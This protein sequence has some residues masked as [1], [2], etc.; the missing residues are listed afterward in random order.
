MTVELR[1]A[2]LSERQI[3]V[4]ERRLQIDERKAALYAGYMIDDKLNISHGHPDERK[5]CA[6]LQVGR[7]TL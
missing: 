2:K 6:E 5:S 7:S 1:G 3:G 4:A